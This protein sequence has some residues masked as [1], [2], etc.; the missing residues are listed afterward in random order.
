MEKKLIDV[1]QHQGTINW[2]KV[3]ASG[4]DYA[5]L[6]L[7][8]I[9]NKKQEIDTKFEYNYTQARTNG[10]N[11]GVY[12]YNYAKSTEMIKKGAEWTISKLSNKALQLPV[13]IDMEDGSLTGLGKNVLTNL[14]I[15]FN[16]LIEKSG[17]WAGVYANKNWFT[18]YLDYSTLKSRYTLWLAQYSN[19]HSLECDIWQYS[20]GGK[21]NGI[22]GDE[23]DLN[24]IYRDLVAE[25][26]GNTKTEVKIDNIAN[27]T[28]KRD[29]IPIRSTKSHGANNVLAYISVGTPVGL[30]GIEGEWGVIPQGYINL[31]DFNWNV[32][33]HVKTKKDG[34]P[35]RTSPSHVENNV[36]THVNIN[37]EFD[38]VQ[39]DRNSTFGR[40]TQ[41]WINLEDCK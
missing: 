16:T 38:I 6:R 13:Y 39:L 28:A 5:I 22:A 24:I 30:K 18:N 1:S 36:I 31:D 37:T 23:V 35:I 27:L 41:G 29:A 10:I 20:E 21:I 32:I 14:C 4:I 34:V 11:V 2:Q 17:R 3:K 8:W 15:E 7:G 12:V 33:K 26:T 40:A 9:G 19:L 25:I